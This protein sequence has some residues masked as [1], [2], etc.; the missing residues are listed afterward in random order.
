MPNKPYGTLSFSVQDYDGET[1]V[2]TMKIAEYNALTYATLLADIGTLRAKIFQEV[3]F[4]TGIC[5]GQGLIKEKQTLFID[6]NN[7]TPPTDENILRGRRWS[8]RY[9]D[10]VTFQKLSAEI[11]C[12]IATDLLLPRSRRADFTKQAWIDFKTAF[13]NV[14]RS[15]HANDVT[16]TAAYLIGRKL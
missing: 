1:G 10:N 13:E 2:A 14:V 9:H 8:L 5:W 12:A 11:P 15:P 3:G 7:P 16:L 6:E 4:N